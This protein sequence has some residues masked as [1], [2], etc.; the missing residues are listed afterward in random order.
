MDFKLSLGVLHG[1][2][3]GLEMNLVEIVCVCMHMHIY[4]R[5][6]YIPVNCDLFRF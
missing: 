1:I 6:V 2:D 5:W 3:V 4:T